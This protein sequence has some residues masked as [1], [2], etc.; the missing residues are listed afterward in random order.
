MALPYLR[1]KEYVGNK[2]AKRIRIMQMNMLNIVLN[3]WKKED[4]RI[5]ESPNEQK[6]SM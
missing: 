3:V 6:R 4:M 2:E 1:L 5:T